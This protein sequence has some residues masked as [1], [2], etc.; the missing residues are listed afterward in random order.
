MQF[1]LIREKL[2]NLEK[3]VLQEKMVAKEQEVVL[4]R[5]VLQE[6]LEWLDQ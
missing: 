2:E 5:M 1:S 4:V 3:M 6:V